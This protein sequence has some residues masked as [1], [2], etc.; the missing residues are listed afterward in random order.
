MA[1]LCEYGFTEGS[2]TV[3]V[4][5]SGNGRNLTASNT[6]TS[7]DAN[8]KNG[9]GGKTKHSGLLGPNAS[10]SSYTVMCWIKRTGTWSAFA[11]MVTKAADNF[12]LECDA[13]GG[14]FPSVYAGI[15]NATATQ[16]LTLNTWF[17]VAYVSNGTTG[18]MYVNGVASGG[19]NTAGTKNFGTGTWNIMPGAGDDG[20]TSA[21]VGVIDEV[22]VFDT[23]LTA[24]DV[25][26][27]MNTPIPP[28]T[29]INGR[30]LL[31]NGTDR[32]L[33]ENSDLLV[34]EDYVPSAAPLPP[35]LIM[36][37]RQK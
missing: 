18:Q 27:W 33:L 11:G 25:T 35:I 12:F 31:E 4:D 1:L 10:D 37:P 30:L 17:H 9:A 29:T 14:Y 2:G 36:A 13:G 16:T 28:I 19:T 20:E 32:Y 23:A 22:R 15:N 34:S 8:G 21:W 5:T 7:W 3:T 6:S 26:T 24:G